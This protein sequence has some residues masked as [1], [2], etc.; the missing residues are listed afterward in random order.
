MIIYIYTHIYIYTLSQRGPHYWVT[1]NIHVERTWG[2]CAE[3]SAT[4]WWI[5]EWTNIFFAIGHRGL[6]WA[7]TFSAGIS[8]KNLH[9]FYGLWWYDSIHRNFIETPQKDRKVNSHSSS[10]QLLDSFTFLSFCGLQ[11]ILEGHEKTIYI[12]IYIHTYI[13]TYIDA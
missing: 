8:F 5:M 13:H 11:N 6:M 3:A 7:V 12:Y 2:S 4:S 1:T 10:D 9:K